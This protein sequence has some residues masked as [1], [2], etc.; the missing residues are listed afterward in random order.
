MESESLNSE[1]LAA[2]AAVDAAAEVE[3]ETP[4]AVA[5]GPERKRKK[6]GLKRG[7]NLIGWLYISPMI[8]GIL[9]FTAIPLIMSIISIFYHWT[10]SVGLFDPETTWVGFGNIKSIF[11]GLEAETY[12]KAVLHTFVYAIQLPVGLVIGLFLALAMNRNMKGVQTFRVLYYLPGVMSVVA[13]TIVWQA[14]FK[15]DGYINGAL[16]LIGIKPFGWLTTKVGA[17]L[18]VNL[19]LIWKGVGYTALMFVAGLQSVST[20]QIEAAKIDGASS[21]TILL[22]I[23]VPALYPILFYLFVTGLMGALQMFNEPYILLGDGYGPG[24]IGMTAVGF[25][26]DQFGQNDLGLA[27]VGA[28]VLAFMIFV[29]T[30]IQMYVDKKREAD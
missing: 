18:T 15:G 10:G 16:G 2:E 14:L 11:G 22:K 5:A 17:A 26:Y 30:A 20:D 9:V 29:V 12:W 13:V 8:V 24:K 4:P 19:L 23:T 7:E 6:G 3:A 1:V 28:W 25:V 21:W 27:S